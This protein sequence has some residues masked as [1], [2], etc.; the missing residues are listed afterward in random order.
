[1]QQ[2]RWLAWIMVILMVLGGGIPVRNVQAASPKISKTSI[3]LKK[4][5]SKTLKMKNIGKKTVVWGTADK[6]IA[7][8]SQKG[9][10]KAKRAGETVIT[11]IVSGSA[12]TCRV[13]VTDPKAD[14]TEKTPA[15]TEPAETEPTET[16]AQETSPQETPETPETPGESSAEE[17]SP[18]PEGT[19]DP[20]K[21]IVSGL[22][23]S[24][25]TEQALEIRWAP[26]P[27]A[28]GYRVRYSTSKSM[29]KAKSKNTAETSI[30]LSPLT[31]HQKY[32]VMVEAWANQN[33]EKVWTAPCDAK[34]KEVTG[35]LVCIDPGHQLHANNG[36]EPV[37]PGSKT[38]KKKVSSGTAG[39]WSKLSEYELNLIVSLQLRTELQKR[40]YQVL[41][42]R[43]KHKVN[44]TNKE[45]ALIANKAKVDIMIRIHANGSETS[46][47]RGAF[48][49]CCTKKNPYYA[50][51]NYKK[52]KRLA[53]QVLKYFVKS[54]GAKKQKI[55]ET[56][57]MTGLNW[58]KVP[59]II[60]EMGEMNNKKEDLQMASKKY[61]KKMVK[62]ISDGVD[63]YFKKK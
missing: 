18:Q 34:S 5:K 36:K 27:G 60:L 6:K 39:K 49:I 22:T 2:K 56:D 24:N 44:I 11:A 42:T 37:G 57:T 20:E 59:A 32:Y 7:T 45:R 55:W 1:M 51:K 33:G 50:K 35:I 62:G 23:I 10:V 13:K 3:T 16:K 14:N 30:T 21:D 58:S 4:G 46:S 25:K 26:L 54:T 41:M 28:E 29:K 40:G 15:K 48:T 17:S 43:T 8:V 38:L 52:S 12:Y 61:Q 53:K 63:A 31:V 47:K 9:K 19:L